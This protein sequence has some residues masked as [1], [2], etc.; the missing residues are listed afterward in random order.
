MIYK[1]VF[2]K[3]I[4]RYFIISLFFAS[5][6]V[7]YGGS[8]KAS[9]EDK[10]EV[11]LDLETK[12]NKKIPHHSEDPTPANPS[13]INQLGFGI[14]DAMILKANGA[15]FCLELDLSKTLI[16]KFLLDFKEMKAHIDSRPTEVGV[17]AYAILGFFQ[18]VKNIYI[19]IPF[20]KGV[21]D[22]GQIDEK[23]GIRFRSVDT[24]DNLECD[25]T[26]GNSLE[27]VT[28]NLSNLLQID[29][30]I[31]NAYFSFQIG[32]GP[33]KLSNK[34]EYTK[35]PLD[36]WGISLINSWLLPQ[37]R[38]E[39][40]Q[41]ILK[42][43]NLNSIVEKA[44]CA[45]TSPQEYYSYSEAKLKK[46]V[47]NLKFAVEFSPI[48]FNQHFSC[49]I[50]PEVVR[51]HERKETLTEYT[52]KT[53]IKVPIDLKFKNITFSLDLSTSF[54]GNEL[55]ESNIGFTIKISSILWKAKKRG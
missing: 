55:F 46:E 49:T 35:N 51:K 5:A 21:I 33:N 6:I 15:S 26:V 24:L 36:A 52:A 53:T 18:A 42:L 19:K 7:V 8:A 28:K 25:I 48:R 54:N 10:H 2:E 11:V 47:Q 29:A 12:S 43:I 13:P 4:K 34:D 22:L 41:G 50:K 38:I 1:L 37:L 3:I 9:E 17:T 32:L 27:R 45:Y 31:K 14:E 39:T 20:R 23:M 16:D 30:K 40:N 44:Y